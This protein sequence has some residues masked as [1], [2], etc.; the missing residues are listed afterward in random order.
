MSLSNP[1]NISAEVIASLSDAL[2]AQVPYYAQN[3]QP[4]LYAAATVCFV[5]A[6]VANGLRVYSRRLKCQKSGWDDYMTL[7]ALGFYVPFYVAS[8][9]VINLGTG[10]HQ[11]VAVVEHPE[12]VRPA[13]KAGVA[14]VI[15]YLFPLYFIKVS[16]HYILQY[17]PLTLHANLHHD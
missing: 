6:W 9:F 4:N 17:A 12:N 15:L 5:A 13:A 16:L 2:R 14:T 7:V 11:V 10:R 3:F 8:I 1:A